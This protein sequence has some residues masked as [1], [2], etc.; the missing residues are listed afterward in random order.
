MESSSTS[1]KGLPK[2]VNKTD[3]AYAAAMLDAEGCISGWTHHGGGTNLRV[4]PIINTNLA[5]VKWLQKL[6]GGKISSRAP[7]GLGKKECHTLC[8]RQPEAARYLKLIRPFLRIKRG[9]AECALAYVSLPWR[10]PQ[11][12]RTLV[13]KIQAMNQG[14]GSDDTVSPHSDV[15]E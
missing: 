13:Q 7:K 10:A 3:I 11:K 5:L 14:A 1:T 9:Q 8:L 4:V 12:K 6:W 2:R 15:M